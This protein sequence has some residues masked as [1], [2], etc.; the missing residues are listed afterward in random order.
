MGG[1]HGARI[2]KACSPHLF[3]DA[4]RRAATSLRVPEPV[5]RA[6]QRNILLITGAVFLASVAA[7]VLADYW[8]A[9]QVRKNLRIPVR[10]HLMEIANAT[11]ASAGRH[12]AHIAGL[13]AFVE[14]R[15]SRAQLDQEFPRFANGLIASTQGIRAVQVIRD[16]RIAY[17]FP[18]A[19][20]KGALGLSL[21]DSDTE[22]TRRRYQL[23]MAADTTVAF[24]P[25]RLLQ[26]GE[27]LVIDRRVHTKY[28]P[29]IDFVAMLVDIPSVVAELRQWER[30]S[31]LAV[32]VLDKMGRVVD[33]TA[34]PM[35]E[36]PERVDAFVRGGKWQV[37]GAPIEGWEPGVRRAML[38]SRILALFII[39]LLPVLAWQVAGRDARLTAEVELRTDSLL[40]L[41]EERRHTIERQLETE[42]AL[43][44]SEERL[45]LALHASRTATYEIDVGTGAMLWSDGVG[46]VVGRDP[47]SSPDSFT[48]S[49][50]YLEPVDGQR[51]VEIFQDACRAPTQGMTEVRGVRADGTRV[52]LQ[53]TWQSHAGADG[54][55]ARIV[56]TMTD[57]S[58]RK[59]LE[60]QFLHAQKMQAMGALAGGIAHDFNNLLT[61]ILGAGQM[62]RTA[63]DAP[64]VPDA[65]RTDLD[66]VLSAGE[67]AS[68]LTG[69]LLAFSRRQVVQPKHFDACDLVG[70]M[71][72]MLRRLVGER[73]RVE[74]ALP[75]ERVP[76]F[77]DQGQLTQVVMN[78][79]VNA[80]DAM[81]KGGLLRISLRTSPPP[82]GVGLPNESLTAA[83]YAVIS[84]ADTGTGID[85][86]IRHMIFDPFFTTKP[87]GQG[88]GLG[89]ATVYGIVIQLGG[90]IRLET[91]PGKGSTFDVYVPLA[92]AAF[93]DVP[94]A[95]SVPNAREGEGRVV[96]LA[97]D[98]QGLRKVIERTLRNAGY[99]L[100]V[101]E[102]GQSALAMSRSYEG[103]IDLLLTDVVMPGVGGV[104]LAAALMAERPTTKVLLMS[105]YPHGPTPGTQLGSTDLPLVA[106][107]FK[108]ADLLAAIRRALTDA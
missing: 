40:K 86:A 6:P 107:P 96:L 7:G 88:T 90:T 103:R 69:Q 63:A 60:E 61:V 22:T 38:P 41:A 3:S 64:T 106:K 75:G 11:A 89:L 76:M 62:A 81:P 66:E 45:R 94:V 72:T 20:N 93:D 1:A 56:G 34:A 15:S 36:H 31:T 18:E 73:I 82:G 25:T 99:S 17:V 29:A 104:E 35:P 95:I 30:D 100:L 16:G 77:A 54:R 37:I 27:A 4:R 5:K 50:G 58:E 10:Q 70:G 65:I 2:A 9:A 74:T 85:P 8:L 12:V 80:R 28:D 67:R 91:E 101:A 78:L 46:H 24:G 33:S 55:V 26:G 105:G 44:A 53:L 87:V 84:V 49:I 83:Q 71:G 48:E 13:A 79:A 43:A 108:P 51:A 21:R 39:V 57:I 68:V 47:A 42:R 14:S 102:D 52:W 19:S 92:D 59:D 23:A 32:V 98:E 97:E